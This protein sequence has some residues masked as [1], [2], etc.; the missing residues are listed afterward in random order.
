M[1]DEIIVNFTP[2]GLIP[3]KEQTEYVPITCN[4]IVEDVLAAYEEGITT[5]HLHARHD[6]GSSAYEAE[7][8]AKIIEKIRKYTKE[9]VI[10]VSLS[11]RNV[12]EFEKRVS[13]LSLTGD[14]KP[15]M[16]SLTLSSLNFNKQASIN[17]PQTIIDMAVLMKKLSIKPELEVFDVGMIN[18]AKYLK[19]KGYIKE[20]FYFNLIL[21]NIACAQA[22]LLHA[23]MMIND[24]PEN[25]FFTIGGIGQNQL[26]MNSIGISIGAG[27]RVG[28]EDNIWFDQNR[29]KLAKNIDLVKR[30]KVIVEANEKKIMKPSAFR[31]LLNLKEGN[32][33]YGEK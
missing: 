32:G 28:I 27:V 12:T 2:T 5:V 15:D 29:T 4:E 33:S 24:L 14:L 16:G 13:P 19:K 26:K 25:S 30:I 11:G 9:L 7:I 21:G 17:A 8:Y 22:D 6:D 1:N 23:G 31:T 3:T 10:C 18:Y 20:P